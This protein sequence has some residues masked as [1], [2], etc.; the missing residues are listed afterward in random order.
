MAAISENRSL[1]A[2]NSTR[3]MMSGLGNALTQLGVSANEL[4]QNLPAA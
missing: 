3:Q 2:D 1:T 4:K